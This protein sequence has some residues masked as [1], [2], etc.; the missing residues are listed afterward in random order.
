MTEFRA[1]TAGR[2]AMLIAGLAILATATLTSVG[3]VVGV[4]MLAAILGSAGWVGSM[5][6]V[7]FAFGQWLR[8]P[9]SIEI[10][11]DAA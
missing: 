10:E 1:T 5:L 6:L 7:F 9:P 11:P 4:C 2:V 8:G 3:L